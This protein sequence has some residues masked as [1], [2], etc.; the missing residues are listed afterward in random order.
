MEVKLI[1]RF[2]NEYTNEVK[3]HLD[4]EDDIA[5]PYF[6]VLLERQIPSKPDKERF[7]VSEYREHHTD[8]ESKLSDLKM[9]LLK[10]INITD[11]LHIRRKILFSLFE[12]EHDLNIHSVLEEMVLIPLINKIEKDLKFE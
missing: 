12:L 2:F 6:Y 4:Y 1:D 5:F 11:E 3:E 8:I 9:L 7:S 10:H